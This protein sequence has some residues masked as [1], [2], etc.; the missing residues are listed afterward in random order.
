MRTAKLAVVTL[1]VFAVCVAA[2]ESRGTLAGVVSDPTGARVA[3][4]EVVAT[5]ASTGVA[6]RSQTTA[7]GAYT[8]PF[9]PPGEYSLKVTA[10]GF[11][12]VERSPI[13]I[14]VQSKVDV[15]VSLELGSVA[16]VV[17]VRADAPMLDTATASTGQVIE[18]R[19][20]VELPLNGRNPL[21]LAQ[22]SP[23]VVSVEGP[24]FLRAFDINGASSL[25]IGGSVSATGGAVTRSNDFTLD[26]APNTTRGNTVAYVPPADA[27]EEFKVET[28]TYDASSGHASGGIINISTKSGSNDLHGALNYF[29]RDAGT[30][31]NTWFNNRAG[32]G[33]TVS[34]FH[35]WGAAAGGPVLLPKL[36]DGRNRTFWFTAYEGIKSSTPAPFLGTVPTERQRQGDFSDLLNAGIR[37]YDP[38]STRPNPASPGRFIRDALPN[39]IVPANRIDAVAKNMLQFF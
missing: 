4:A 16:D 35:Q 19:R 39:N 22:M 31:A 25:S 8:I 5:S 10:Q 15:D 21:A 23:G 34:P 11:K 14:Q 38:F 26:G 1:Q 29:H 18:N 6:Y 28:A 27:V 2:Q 7:A 20:I 30:T 9:L 12:T 33:K 36:Y 3:N 37:I 24:T 13:L 32:R 17:N